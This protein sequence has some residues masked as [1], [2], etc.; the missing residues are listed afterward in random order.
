MIGALTDV[1]GTYLYVLKFIAMGT[2]VLLIISGIDDLFIDVVYWGR[3]ML[4]AVTIYRRHS[5]GGFDLLQGAPEK[6][7]AI[8][9][10][11]WQETGVVGPMAELAASTLDYENYHIFVGTY[12]NDPDTQRE[13]D[14]VCARFPNVHK[15]VCA[16]PGPTS[17]A[18]CL[19]NVLDAILQ[20]E[21]QA[22]FEFSGFILHDAEDVISPQELRLFN[23]LVDRKDLIQVPVYPFERRWTHFTSMHYIDEFAELHGKDLVVRE[24]LAGQVPSA[25]VGT[26][27]SRRAMLALI[28]DGDGIAFDV[29]S[30]TED[31]D[32]GFRLKARGM[33]EV[34]V[35]YPVW[36]GED[37]PRR[38]GRSRDQASVVCVREYFPDTLGTAVRQ[39]ARWIIG[40]VF[41]GYRTHR[42]TRN[43]IVNYF[44][45][46]DRRGAI[47]NFISF[48]A[49][50]ILGQMLLLGLLQM[51]PG[52]PR[53]LSIFEQDRWFQVVLT[54]N[55][56]LMANRIAQRLFFVSRYYGLGQALLSLPRLMWGAFINFLANVRAIRQIIQQGDPRR[57]AWDK[58]THDFPTVG[59]TRRSR[60]PLGEILVEQGAL[61]P[62]QLEQALADT[63]PGLRL[64]SALVHSRLISAGQLAGALAV[65]NGV[66]AESIE[67]YAPSASLMASMERDVM[68]RYGILPL[69][70][71]GPTLVVASEW[72]I[73][74][75][76]LAALSRR[77]KRPVRYVI[78][79]RGEVV[80][81]TR[82]LLA[83]DDANP[84]MRLA[85]WVREGR[86]AASEAEPLW[87]RYVNEQVSLGE[88]LMSLGHVEP[89]AFRALMLRFGHSIQLGEFL[90]RNDVITE[91]VLR[92]A[93]SLQQRLQPTLEAVV[94]PLARQVLEA[95]AEPAA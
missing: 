54:I 1:L 39:K 28:A 55:L 87:R 57:V 46:R 66:E 4:R 82:C 8:M 73:D 19:N 52:A 70:E 3:R 24:A 81:N 10:P 13:V 79:H 22:K 48:F 31:Y 88:L 84:R 63:V 20:F 56:A 44:L 89:T 91:D 21:R 71:E 86:V 6:A 32:I 38:F 64:G 16:R 62:A 17:K 27:F 94:E 7:L 26:C 5:R 18:D 35:R 76:S 68:L 80:V 50:L 12:P 83:D 42:W 25:G 29:Q 33:S 90:V 77:L 40:I 41:Q 15:V 36:N 9:V 93:L 51:L 78:A 75:V 69:R 72:A 14:A 23:H 58:T 2:A 95:P 61:T 85:R 47:T 37:E 49:I 53:F 67:P 45:W 30:L 43:P 34:F 65:Q 60:R 59:T 92:R 74:P 11:A